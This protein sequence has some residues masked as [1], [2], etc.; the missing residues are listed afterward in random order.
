MWSIICVRN[1]NLCRRNES[2]SCRGSSRILEVR[3]EQEQLRSEKLTQVKDQEDYSKK[4]MSASKLLTKGVLSKSLYNYT[5]HP[6]AYHNPI[7]ISIFG[8]SVEMEDG[9]IWT[10]TSSD[11]TTTL[12]WFASDVLIISQNH[13]WFSS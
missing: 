8:D 2:Y 7:T 6:G 13:T 4:V 11:A 10:I 12:N 5:S 1:V 9:S 3:V